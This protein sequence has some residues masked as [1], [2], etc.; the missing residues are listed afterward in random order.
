[1]IK[2]TIWLEYIY[3]NDC[4]M[5]LYASYFMFY[6]VQ[7]WTLDFVQG[8]HYVHQGLHYNEL[9]TKNLIV[10]FLVHDN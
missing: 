5:V 3:Q 4:T 6:T 7:L 9:V 10:L 8:L 1:M 2:I